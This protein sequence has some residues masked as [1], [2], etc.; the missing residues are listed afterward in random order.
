MKWP[1]DPR[2][3]ILIVLVLPLLVPTA[4]ASSGITPAAIPV[5]AN[6]NIQQTSTANVYQTTTQT[7]WHNSTPVYGNTS[8]YFSFAALGAVN[9]TATQFFLTLWNSNYYLPYITASQGTS[10]FLTNSSVFFADFQLTPINVSQQTL[11]LQ[12]PWLENPATGGAVPLG[13]Y[14]ILSNLTSSLNYLKSRAFNWTTNGTGVFSATY[15]LSAPAQMTVNA[16][17]IYVPFP[18]NVS[19]N[20]SSVKVQ[21][22][23]V[24][25]RN[26]QVVPGGA[27][28]YVPGLAPN[29]TTNYTVVFTAAPYLQ[30]NSLLLQINYYFLLSGTTY[31]MNITWLNVGLVPFNGQVVIGTNLPDNVAP[32]SLNISYANHYVKSSFILVQGTTITLLP[33]AVTIQPGV[34][35]LFVIHFSFVGAIPSLA[36]AAGQVLFTAGG[37]QVTLG[38]TLILAAIAEL[39]YLTYYF[40]RAEYYKTPES[41][42]AHALGGLVLLFI[43]TMALIGVAYLS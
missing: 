22:G 37:T 11:R 40:A 16:S 4:H 30:Q 39:V 21:I 26:S 7:F 34:L 32:T 36:F 17:T 33:G 6:A 38:D 9:V 14:H 3:F 18:G 25:Y 27:Y 5:K 8:A 20:Y 1:F 24:T 28:I 19:V 23:N 35:V 43:A 2:W 41:E 42:Y 13:T 10:T 29:Q 12:I 31:Q 15:A